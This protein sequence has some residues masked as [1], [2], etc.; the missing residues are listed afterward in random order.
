MLSRAIIAELAGQRGRDEQALDDYVTLARET[1][2][3]SI[4][5][6][7]ARIST[8][9]RRAPVG[10]EMANLWLEQQPDSIEARQLL[11]QNLVDSGRYREAM[12][13]LETLLDQGSNVEF[14]SFP[15]GSPTTP[16][17]TY[18]LMR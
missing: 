18:C 14:A 5:Q 2:N 13:Q 17:L 3:L 4:I 11:L 10:M 16:A 1:R 9:M 6:R 7:T 12:A 8:F 15:K